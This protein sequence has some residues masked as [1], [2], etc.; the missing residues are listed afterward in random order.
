MQLSRNAA[1][2]GLAIASL[3]LPATAAERDFTV[4]LNVR[5]RTLEGTVLA[6][7]AERVGL[8]ARDGQL[9]SFRPAEAQEFRRVADG[10]RAF[11][12]Q[13]MKAQLLQEFGPGFQVAGT[14]HYLVVHAAG[15]RVDWSGRFEELY[16]GFVH[17]F[18]AR[19]SAPRQPEFP[20]VAVVFRDQ[21]EFQRYANKDSA[22]PGAGVLG[23]YSPT[24]NR[25]AM[26]ERHLE[27][28]NSEWPTN[29]ETI[30]HE[31]THQSAFNTGIH[32]R[33]SPNPRWLVEGLGTMFESRGVWDSVRHT[34]LS[35]RI[36]RGRLDNFRQYATSR[37]AKG[38]LLDLV[39]S[40]RMFRT[41]PE[42][43]YAES[44]AFTFFVAETDPRKFQQYL[45]RTAS[46]TGGKSDSESQR[47]AEFTAVFGNDLPMLET[48][49][50]RYMAELK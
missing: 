32:D 22:Q 2:L 33:F 11:A 40:D 43:A 47:V 18:T 23:Y 50:L 31:A 13:E 30:I 17:Y 12:Q 34:Q 27:T 6:A 49:F 10:F 15:T 20:L 29:G 14:G 21:S 45:R 19:G 36:N 16:R 24:T 48:R 35:E 46:S 39:S 38:A 44:W 5:G 41:D 9:W 1:F 28:S 26:Y 25:V 3:T 4:R 42:G 7:D 37:R 8:L